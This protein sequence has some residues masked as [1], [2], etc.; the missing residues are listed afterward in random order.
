MKIMAS[1]RELNERLYPLHYAMFAGDSPGPL[2]Y[3][4]TRLHDW[5]KEDTRLPITACS[6]EARKQVDAALEHAGLI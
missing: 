4:L 6:S 2:K 1:A 3:A 5:I